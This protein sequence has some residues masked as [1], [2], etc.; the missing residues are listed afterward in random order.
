MI[1]QLFPMEGSKSDSADNPLRRQREEITADIEED[2]LER[3]RVPA[4][5]SAL[6]FDA[7]QRP[8]AIVPNGV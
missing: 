5:R 3:W 1:G 2:L 6:H 4:C 8:Q 7:G